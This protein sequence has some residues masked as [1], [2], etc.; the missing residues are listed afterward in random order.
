MASEASA[1]VETAD[2]CPGALRLHAAGDGLLARIRLPGGRLRS[3]QLAAVARAAELGNGL[4][5][6][7]G[8]A[9][10]QVRGLPQDA[11]GELSRL[12]S[13]AGL[14]PSPEHD[15]VRNVLASPLAGRHPA[16]LAPTD[17][18]V[19]E[20]DR[21]LCA[22]EALAR[23]PG[24]FL[25]AVDDGSGLA[26]GHGAD[27]TLAAR[28]GED[29]HLLL[30]GTPT[31]V[32]VGP[33]QGAAAALAAARAFVLE[34]ARQHAERAW[35]IAEL[36]D[37]PA[38]VA[39]RLGAE[40]R[41]T[42]AAGSSDGLHAPGGPPRSGVSPGAVPQRDGR[43][44]LTA[45]VPLARLERERA[46]QL[47][48][49]VERHGVGELRLSPWRTITILDLP[50]EHVPAA[51]AGLASLGLVLEE[52]GWSGLSACSG[53]GACTQAREDVRAAAR[54]R[55]ACR[56]GASGVEHW[57]ACER[58]CGERADARVAVAAQADGVSVRIG[59]RRLLLESFDQAL[60][61]LGQT[62]RSAA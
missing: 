54:A 43:T 42:A 41:P 27:V 24:R 20:L 5:E 22:E 7:T 58:R 46:R 21:G 10:L 40:L 17:E 15:R 32:R 30:A 62:A 9:N 3:H 56:D 25:F 12:L 53:L 45:L 59:E 1:H 26:L 38:R 31:S 37:G 50:E 33:S 61:L 51:A 2:R 19:A 55:V 35:R 57:S 34:R 14:L 23:L 6:L 29:F 16:A 44:A 11:A 52:G 47:A 28:A 60:E 49:L 4:I 36:S 13:E 8:R 39:T 18:I 48:D